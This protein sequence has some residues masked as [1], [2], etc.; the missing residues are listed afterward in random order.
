MLWPGA[1]AVNALLKNKEADISSPH[2]RGMINH[3]ERLNTTAGWVEPR[4]SSFSW[5]RPCDGLSTAGVGFRSLFLSF[6]LIVVCHSGLFAQTVG[7]SQPE[8]SLASLQGTVKVAGQQGEVEVVPDVPVKLTGPSSTSP[9]L[10]A[11]T[12]AE[13]HYA[14]T[15]LLPG[16][17]ALEVRLEGFKTFVENIALKP[18]DSKIENISLEL[19]KVVEQVEVRE[20]A[21]PVAA[22]SAVSKAT[23]STRQLATLPLSEQKFTAALPMVPGV[24]RTR[25]GKLNFNGAPEEQGMLLIDS[26]QTVDPVTGSFSIPIPLDAIQ[27]MNINEIPY[28]AEYGGFSGGLTAI[29]TKPPTGDWHYGVNDFFPRFRG[30][31]GHLVGLEAITP[32]LFFGG[33]LVKKKLN[34]LEA[35]TYDVQKIPVRGL[36]WPLNETKRQGFNTLTSFQ[37]LLSTRHILSANVN[38]FSNRSQFADITALIPQTA[39]ADEGQKGVSIGGT[40]SYQFSSGSF[41]STAF[42]YS[43]FDSNAHGHGPDDMLMSPEGW[44]GDYFNTWARASNQLELSPIYKLPKKEW[45]GHHELKAGVDVSHRSYQGTSFSRPIQILRQDGTLAEQIDFQPAGTL[46]A[47]DTEV[48]EFVQDHWTINDDLALD[49]GGRLSS[50]SIGRSTAFAPRAGVVYS[51]GGAHKTIVRAGV[52]LFDNRVP[53]LAADFL[54][55]PTRVVST[56]DESGTLV[57]PPV[58]FQNAYVGRASGGGYVPV[59]RDLDTSPRNFTTNLEVDRELRRGMVIRASYLYSLTQD[60]YVVT[61]VSG[62]PGG[63]SLLGLANTGGSH[64]QEFEATLHYQPSE[65]IAI[66]VSYVRS[67]ARGDLNSLSD[68]FVPLEQPV[69][70]PDFTGTLAQ[71]VPNRVV[72]WGEVPLPWKFKVSPVADIHTGLPYSEID[73]FQNYVGTPNGQRFPTFFSLDV[74]IYREFRLRFRFFGPL[75]NRSIRIGAY[76]LNLTEHSNPLEIYN[77]VTSPVFGHLVGFQHQVDGLIIDMVN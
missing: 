2:G 73:S 19:N 42:R 27:T 16:T 31:S 25:D 59:S 75:K 72:G 36:A 71:N 69:I 57:Q 20:S 70:R 5:C 66:N 41:L 47:Q 22:E 1:D 14:F 45:W 18:G 29:E 39:S 43:R 11:T 10:S 49:L 52:G 38:G 17:Y 55:N 7:V 34:F 44:G 24:V 37:A 60:I 30:R 12:D 56:Y 50:Q 3:L 58:V 62:A 65:R 13:G 54:D 67:H 51:P 4:C 53:L 32:R 28:G 15:K 6:A 77:N 33:P 76:S 64:Y 63:T 74:K 8:T 9:S 35:V 61:P 48:A 68:V 21:E 26:V 40:D 23:V 46:Q